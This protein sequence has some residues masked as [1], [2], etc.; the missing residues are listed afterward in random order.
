MLSRR[1][2]VGADADLCFPLRSFRSGPTY[3][4]AARAIFRLSAGKPRHSAFLACD[5]AR[6][7]NEAKKRGRRPGEKSLSP[8]RRSAQPVIPCQRISDLNVGAAFRRDNTGCGTRPV[9][10]SPDGAFCAAT[11][12]RPAP[13]PGPLTPALTFPIH[14]DDRIKRITRL[15]TS[16]IRSSESAPPDNGSSSSKD[17]FPKGSRH[18]CTVC[19]LPPTKYVGL[20]RLT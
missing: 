13:T 19:V 8:E 10:R 3:F 17:G 20:L 9:V 16:M 7:R 1:G 4:A 2:A 5:A 6:K 18:D 11:G 15:R 14:F 12:I